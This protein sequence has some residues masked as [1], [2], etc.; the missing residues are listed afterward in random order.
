MHLSD[1]RKIAVLRANGIGDLMFA[2]PALDALRAAYP[3]AHITLLGAAHHATLLE[4][5]P[6]PVDRVVVVP[7]SRGVNEVD[8]PERAD[9]LEEF[10]DAMR[11][12]QFDLALQMHG[13]GR[14]SNPF[15]RRLAARVTVGLKGSDA[16]ALDR[17][18]PYTYWQ[19]EVARY[20]EVVSLVGARPTTLVPHLTVTARDLAEAEEVVP[21]TDAPLVLLNPGA[22]DPRRRWTAA[23]FAA[24]G[25]S[26]AELGARVILHGCGAERE[27]TR[28]VVDL[29][30]ADAVDVA[31]HLSLR[32]LVGLAS[33]CSVVVSNDSGPLYVC[34]AAGA[35]TVGIY[36]CGNLPTSGMLTRARHRPVA[37]W[38]LA[39]PVCGAHCVYDG[40]DHRTSFVADVE[41]CDV[42]AAALEVSCCARV[43]LGAHADTSG[44]YI[45][46]RDQLSSC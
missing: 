20:I 24:V 4:G 11:A 2:L 7:P 23:G 5:R 14:Y 12:E 13:G 22:T 31:G 33:R 25:D 45:A 8:G 41:P 44:S 9:V 46:S 18:I 27:I 42:I 34:A 21:S 37:A 43:P 15:I 10:V 19:P 16:P 29:M 36:W 30:R 40:C 39:C 17:W 1:V 35:P 38:R 3:R 28:E 6:T 32:A 26:L